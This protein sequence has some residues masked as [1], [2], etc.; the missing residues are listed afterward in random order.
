MRRYLPR[1]SLAPT[2]LQHLDSWRFGLLVLLL[3]AFIASHVKNEQL[4]ADFWEHA[5]A[6]AEYA[7]APLR[8]KNPILGTDEPH[9]GLHPYHLAVGL[10][11]RFFGATAISALTAFSFVNV[12]LFAIFLRRFA[13]ELSKARQSGFWALLFVLLLW[14]KD[15]WIYSAFFSA[16]AIPFVAP[17][18]ATFS[19]ALTLAAFCL[20]IKLL[21]GQT[22]PGGYV[23]LAL[24]CALASLAHPLTGMF[25][26]TG[27]GALLVSEGRHAL[28]RNAAWLALTA[29]V[30]AAALWAWPHYPFFDLIGSAEQ[31]E[32][33]FHRGGLTF[34]L[35]P[36]SKAYPALLALPALI[37]SIR[38]SPALPLL[39]LPSAL[40]FAAGKFLAQPYFGRTIS[41]VVLILQIA[42]ASYVARSEQASWRFNWQSAVRVAY[43][44]SIVG[45]LIYCVAQT[46]PV[47]EASHLRR[48]P[49][50]FDDLRPIAR[51]VGDEVVLTDLGSAW[52]LPAFGVKVL[53]HPLQLA[54]TPDQ[55]LRNEAVKRF[56]SASTR[57]DERRRILRRWRVR[58]VLVPDR[59]D[60]STRRDLTLLGRVVQRFG[61]FSLLQAT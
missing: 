7:R 8:P 10:C 57:Q 28:G 11:A 34:Y 61:R 19:M 13:F 45:A 39:L 35:N 6:V 14:P 50:N 41:F 43:L 32:S 25:L 30:S 47:L 37:T 55:A 54:F 59:A 46:A 22:P 52:T 49:R 18:P 51:A 48:L 40:M 20:H 16:R 26:C 56:F 44:G 21:R 36:L 23:V 12:L 3:C 4:Y 9:K 2:A 53:A 38:S 17:Y 15:Q 58:Y 24:L 42:L 5:A 60:V 27:L 29:A 1:I 31:T 33:G